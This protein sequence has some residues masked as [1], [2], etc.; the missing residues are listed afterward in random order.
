MKTYIALITTMLVVAAC[1]KETG[2]ASGATSESSDER[3]I[4]MAKEAV[5]KQLKDP[6]SAIFEGMRVT[7]PGEV[8]GVVNA[9]NSFGGYAGSK[10]FKWTIIVPDYVNF[11]SEGSTDCR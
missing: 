2:G 4:R 5:I 6:S 9:K 10:R 1:G 7:S 8:C 3:S 11:L